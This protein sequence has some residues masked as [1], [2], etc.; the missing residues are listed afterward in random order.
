MEAEATAHIGAEPGEHGETRTTRRN[1]HRAKSSPLRPGTWTWRP[2]RSAPSHSFPLLE[3]R[4]RIDRVLY[5][6]IMESYVQGVSTRRVGD[7]VKALGG[8]TGI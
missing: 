7:Q 3:C 8:D 2:P 1:G 6:V 4:R 5:A